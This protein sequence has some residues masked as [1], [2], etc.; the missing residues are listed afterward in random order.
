MAIITEE[1]QKSKI[2]WKKLGLLVFAYLLLALVL[3]FVIRYIFAH[4]HHF[5]HFRTWLALIILFAVMIAANMT[6]LPLP[7][8][9]AFALIAAAIWNPIL[10]AIV[11]SLGA[12]AA[13]LVG[14]YFGN[15][16][17]KIAFPQDNKGYKAVQNWFRGNGF[18]AIAILSFQPILPFEVA[19]LIAG[20]ARMSIY[21]FL[22]ADLLG[23]FP[24]YLIIVFLGERL[25]H[26]IPFFRH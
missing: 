25:I 4:Y 2:H 18:W 14:Y 11:C 7:F 19:G 17:K 24:K 20:A 21:K 3:G 16:G 1:T 26:L 9:A 13:D 23:K 10:V 12:T 8:G 15:L 22:G 5:V 6:F